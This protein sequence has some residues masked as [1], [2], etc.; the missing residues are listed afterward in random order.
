MRTGTL[1]VVAALALSVAP[2][3][4]HGH[5]GSSDVQTVVRGQ[6]SYRERIALTPGAVF[7]ATLVDVSRADASAEV[8]GSVRVETPGSVP[9]RFEIPYDAAKIDQRRSYAVRARILAGAR[10]LFTTDKAYPVLTR[11][12]GTDVD[13]LLVRVNARGTPASAQPQSATLE[14]T[15]WTL[16]E[17]DGKPVPSNLPQEPHLVFQAEPRRVSGS[18][19][20]NRLST[21]YRRDGERLGFEAIASTRR[22][23]IGGGMDTEDAFL[24]AL[25]NV[26]AFR[27]SGQRLELVDEGGR[28]LAVFQVA[29]G[30]ATKGK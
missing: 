30:A 7:E 1:V 12:A 22:A 11:G 4:Q 6:A 29:A 16:I 17:L 3:A 25:Q 8:I 18:G 10:L 21:D 2:A 15:H 13:L 19:G 27:I 5:D 28:T 23:C 26:R 20:C 24:R 14:G 9:I